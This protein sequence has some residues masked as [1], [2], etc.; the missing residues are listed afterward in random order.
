VLALCERTV[1]QHSVQGLTPAPEG[2]HHPFLVP[3]GI[4]PAADGF[5]ALA[6]HQQGF[7]ETLCKALGAED[8]LTEPRYASPE[9]RV[10]HRVTLI[11]VLSKYTARFTKAELTTRLGGVIPFGPVMNIADITRDPH[12][13]A[14]EMIVSV[15]QPG[16]EPIRIVGVPIKMTG[17][18]GSVRR[19]APLLGEDTRSRLRQAGLSDSEIEQLLEKRAAFAVKNAEGNPP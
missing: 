1:Y 15:E 7:F 12:Y 2:N 4:Y 9:R 19:R 5:V 3:F 13:A 17:T 11:E 8:V 6:A 14:R 18:P 16:D 10:E